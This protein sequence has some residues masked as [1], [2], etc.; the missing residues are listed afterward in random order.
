MRN[1]GLGKAKQTQTSCNT[2]NNT[3][4]KTPKLIYNNMPNVFCL[5]CSK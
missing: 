1:D 5:Y 3:L 4:L 2:H